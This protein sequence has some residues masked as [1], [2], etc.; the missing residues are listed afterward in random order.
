MH[1]RSEEG[2]S[3]RG[4]F[5]FFILGAVTGAAAAVLLREGRQVAENP[6]NPV[7][8]NTQFADPAEKQFP[9]GVD[10]LSPNAPV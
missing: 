4:G 2:G 5:K 10:P 8:E 3:R 9:M 7:N 6:E 1:R